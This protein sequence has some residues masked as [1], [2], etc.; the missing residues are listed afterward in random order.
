MVKGYFD[1]IEKEVEITEAKQG[2][3]GIVPIAESVVEGVRLAPLGTNRVTISAEPVMVGP[4][5]VVQGTEATSTGADPASERVEGA[6][7]EVGIP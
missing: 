3:G 2:E 5:P 4:D 1:M 7:E 6:E